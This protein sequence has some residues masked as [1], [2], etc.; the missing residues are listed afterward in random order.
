MSAHVLPVHPD[1]DQLR[2][3]AKE[4]KRAADHGDPEALARIRTVSDEVSLAGAQLA[5]AREYGFPSWRRL[6][7]EAQ[8]LAAIAD[9]DVD[10]LSELVRADPALAAAPVRASFTAEPVHPLDYIGMGRL[11]GAWHHDRAGE[12]SRV[13]VAGSSPE[14]AA[15]I[16]AASHGEPLMVRTLIESGADLEATGP[17]APGSGTALAHAVHYGIVE[18]V[19]LLVAAGAIVHDLVEA[20]GA[21]DIGEFLPA[22]AEERV[23]ALR[24]AAVCERL[25]VIDALLETGI[26]VNSE[27]TTLT[28]PHAGTALHR[29]AHEGKAHSVRHLLEH[30]ADQD[31]PIAGM[32]ALQWC[33]TRH[34]ELGE[35]WGHNQVEAILAG[36]K[37]QH[38]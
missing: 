17:A 1:L 26:D 16:T 23:L 33:R 10:A 15:L 36:H 38:G 8:R 3:Q 20:A 7:A 28:E 12:L 34:A 13:L 29:A 5:L 4:L 25:D 2:R 22:P 35:G 19:D 9:G 21:G 30:G 31:L 24:A 6:N 37:S 18:A 11:H 14:A 32:T 27:F